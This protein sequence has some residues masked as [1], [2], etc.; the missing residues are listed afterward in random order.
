MSVRHA[1]PPTAP[2]GTS[3]P[4]GAP[5]RGAAAGQRA[6]ARAA[7]GGVLP[8]GRRDRAPRLEE[9][10][11]R[12]RRLNKTLFNTIS[13]QYDTFLIPSSAANK[14]LSDTIDKCQ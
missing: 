4:R 12:A 10:R 5:P 13:C 1:L 3:L 2:R 11:G 9:R 8:R 14:T 7:A 6:A